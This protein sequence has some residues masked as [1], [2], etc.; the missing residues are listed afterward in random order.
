MSNASPAPGVEPPAQPLT[1]VAVDDQA[2]A[3]TLAATM[4]RG[5]VA[6]YD[7]I[8]GADDSAL[9]NLT[10]VRDVICVLP[11][12]ADPALTARARAAADRARPGAES[13]RIVVCELWP[14]DQRLALPSALGSPGAIWAWLS[15]LNELAERGRSGAARRNSPSAA[16]AANA[17]TGPQLEP[18]RLVMATDREPHNYGHVV[19]DHGAQVVV[20]FSSPS[21]RVADVAIA[22]ADLR[23]PDGSPLRWVDD[24]QT[25]N[26]P[27]LESEVAPRPIRA[28]LPPVPSLSP[29]FIPEPFR[30]WLQDIA[31]RIGCDLAF[32]AVAAVIA[33]ATVVGRSIGIRPKRQDDWLVVPNLWGAIIGPP[34]AL[35]SPALKEALRP[36][37]RLIAEARTA[38]EGALRGYQADALLAKIEAENARDELKRTAKQTG[39]SDA[40][41]AELARKA[42]ATIPA[43]PVCKRYQTS[44]GTVEKIGE[45]LRDNRRGILVCRD[46]L[47]G[48]LRSLE[49]PGRES[50]KAFYLESWNGNGLAFTYD[51]IGRGTIEIPAPCLS[52][53]GGLQPG[54]LVKLLKAVA[55]GEDADDG[56]VSRFQLLAWPDAPGEWR[57]VDRWPDTSAKNRAFAVF[58]ALDTIDPLK[59]KAEVETPGDIPF[60]RFDSEAQDCFDEWRARLENE[61]LQADGESP[62]IESHLAKFRSLMP[63]LAL[64]FH[65]IEVADASSQQ[66][67]H[68]ETEFGAT[69]AGIVSVRSTEL[70]VAWCDFL[71]AHARRAYASVSQADVEPARALAKR[72]KGGELPNPFQ[73]RDI[74]RRC[75]SGL[76]TPDN[77]RH[78]LA[79]LEENGWV[80]GVDVPTAGRPRTDYYIH[81]TIV[82]NWG[83]CCESDALQ[84]STDKTDESPQRDGGNP[85][86]SALSGPEESAS[87]PDEDADPEVEIV[88]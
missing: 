80:R 72:I 74:Y 32:P 62:L 47:T 48:W 43:E 9:A 70:A 52:L 76:D 51:R 75:W 57:N 30:A 16:P 8:I 7:D 65:L 60:L 83:V 73:A 59:L 1:L 54:P 86:L 55:R 82:A 40:E 46:E 29:S 77:A 79:I 6:T 34:G 81:P 31:E 61:K 26:A 49:K 36:L 85:L 88:L 50:D 87:G 22:K 24:T 66:G 17:Q 14:A 28:D 5:A 3:A 27:P 42:T 78:A 67:D 15:N 25:Q 45:L 20:R 10:N 4:G 41:L 84:G 69:A 39:K 56:L 68:S 18:G 64:L 53:L 38:H 19:A 12:D 23:E 33:L 2:D 37:N 35:K 71:E 58:R 11:G 63:S 21:G 13:V 44:D